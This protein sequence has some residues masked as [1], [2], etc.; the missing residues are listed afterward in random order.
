MYAHAAYTLF[1][2]DL[3]AALVHAPT[4]LEVA[5]AMIKNEAL[6]AQL[7][8]DGAVGSTQR[9]TYTHLR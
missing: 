5:C 2:S 6:T 1:V 3:D 7:T 4:H 8:V 9:S